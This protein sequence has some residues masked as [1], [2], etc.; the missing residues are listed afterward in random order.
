MRV[1]ARLAELGLRLPPPP[2][3]PPGVRV[4]FAWVRVR[5]DRAY[6]AGHGPLTDDAAPAGP[7]GAVG[8]EVSLAEA[9][10]AA[11]GAALAML[12]GLRAELGDLDRVT[13]WLTV[14][15]Y[16]QCAPG[17]AQTTAVV[18]GFS[19][20]ILDVYGPEAGRHARSAPGVV[21]LPLNL[22]VV[23]EA[24]VEVAP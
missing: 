1:E 23:V 21:A 12:A 19:D 10:Q 17:F 24:E 2:R 16:V 5:G 8:A 4:P 3:A 7:F 11:R 14:R 22:P 15:G 18:N 20:L 9:V 6:L 13:A